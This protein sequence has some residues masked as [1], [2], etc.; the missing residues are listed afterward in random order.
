MIASE[1][2]MAEK[3]NINFETRLITNLIIFL[4]SKKDSKYRA[5]VIIFSL[6]ESKEP[7]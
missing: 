1:L 4:I 6:F 2:S 7:R 3:A 5:K